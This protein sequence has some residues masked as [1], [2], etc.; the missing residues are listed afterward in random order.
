MDGQEVEDLFAKLD[1]I[2]SKR[3]KLKR[4]LAPLDESHSNKRCK[5]M[6]E[7]GE[8]RPDEPQQHPEPV[9]EFKSSCSP[10]AAHQNSP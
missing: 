3:L 6:A 5:I 1:K 10:Q 8:E 9:G 2:V 7:E 4:A